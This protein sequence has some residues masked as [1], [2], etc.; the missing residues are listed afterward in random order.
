MLYSDPTEAI[1]SDLILE[2]VARYFEITERHD[3][4]GGIAYETLTHNSKLKEI[5]SDELNP[6]IDQIL[7]QDRKYIKAKLVPQIFSYFIARLNKKI[8]ADR[9]A[10]QRFQQAEDEREAW[11]REHHGTYSWWQYISAVIVHNVL[12]RLNHFTLKI[13]A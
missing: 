12:F 6:F 5:P 1:H 9:A 4:G 11:S 13:R 8:L 10:I 3:T 2:S 7:F